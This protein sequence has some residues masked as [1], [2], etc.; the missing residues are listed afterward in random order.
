MCLRILPPVRSL[1]VPLDT[2]FCIIFFL[3]LVRYGYAYIHIIV[4]T[5]EICREWGHGRLVWKFCCPNF[6]VT[7]LKNRKQGTLSANCAI[8][9]SSCAGTCGW[10]TL[11]MCR[12]NP[13]STS[14]ATVNIPEVRQ[15]YFKF[16]FD[17]V[18]WTTAASLSSNSLLCL[19]DTQTALH[20]GH[21]ASAILLTLLFTLPRWRREKGKA[22]KWLGRFQRVP[23]I[24]HFGEESFTFTFKGCGAV[25]TLK[26]AGSRLFTLG[27]K[28]VDL[29]Q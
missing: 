5:L 21:L 11:K 19:R 13:H 6:K 24:I 7:L 28:A 3:T 29:G 20:F 10:I 23:P 16:P 14:L 9:N 17:I 12:R 4:C 26:E 25:L 2:A 27:Q 22:L 15:F 1:D 18:N 8:S